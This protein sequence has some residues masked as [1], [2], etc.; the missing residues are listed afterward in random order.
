MAQPGRKYDI[1]KIAYYQ[2]G[3]AD[4][5]KSR[6]HFCIASIRIN[7]INPLMVQC[8]AKQNQKR[9]NI[10]RRNRKR[11]SPVNLGSMTENSILCHKFKVNPLKITLDLMSCVIQIRPNT[12]SFTALIVLLFVKI[13]YKWLFGRKR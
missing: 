13:R 11:A 10:N 7:S 4:S 1:L 8:K 6:N 9:V 3:D 12:Q 2:V 5:R